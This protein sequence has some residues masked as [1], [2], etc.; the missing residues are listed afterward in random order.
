[1]S[2]AALKASAHL[3]FLLNLSQRNL[4]HRP[5]LDDLGLLILLLLGGLKLLI[6][7]KVTFLN[8]RAVGALVQLLRAHTT[9]S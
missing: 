9:R 1:M 5:V 6:M 2:V 7:S 8:V 3:L 4:D